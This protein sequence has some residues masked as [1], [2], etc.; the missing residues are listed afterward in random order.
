MWPKLK[1]HQSNRRGSGEQNQRHGASSLGVGHH[2]EV[3]GPRG[4]PCRTPAVIGPADTPYRIVQC[5]LGGGTPADVPW[6][7]ICNFGETRKNHL[8]ELIGGCP[9]VLRFARVGFG[10]PCVVGVAMEVA[11][12]SFPASTTAAGA[13]APIGVTTGTGRPAAGTPSE[14]SSVPP[15]DRTAPLD[16]HSEHAGLAIG[17]HRHRSTYE[18]RTNA[19]L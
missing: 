16:L 8:K 9:L 1:P 18:R 7:E 14:A 6:G 3:R 12:A 10:S 15:R 19:R 11:S 13:T 2:L 17:D 5:A 4:L